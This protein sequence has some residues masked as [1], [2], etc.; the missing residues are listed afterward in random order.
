MIISSTQSFP[1][2][3]LKNTLRHTFHAKKAP[4]RLTLTRFFCSQ[5][6]SQENPRNTRVNFFALNFNPPNQR[7]ETVI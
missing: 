4:I 5:P 3:A 2:K 7:L 1:L 6:K